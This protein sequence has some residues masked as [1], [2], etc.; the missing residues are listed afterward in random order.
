MFINTDQLIKEA[1]APF[2][3]IKQ[4]LIDDESPS[5]PTTAI[6]PSRIVRVCTLTTRESCDMGLEGIVKCM[7]FLEDG[8]ALPSSTPAEEILDQMASIRRRQ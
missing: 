5:R 8:T 3:F 7:V 6:C 1:K 2:V 4:A